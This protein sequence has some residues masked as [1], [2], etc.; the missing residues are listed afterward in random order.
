MGQNGFPS[1]EAA[2]KSLKRQSIVVSPLWGVWGGPG[3]EE[4]LETR[5]KRG[6]VPNQSQC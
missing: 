4:P 6:F 1:N 3:S 5:R 2:D